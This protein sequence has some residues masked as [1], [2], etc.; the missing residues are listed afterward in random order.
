MS[1][2]YFV[3]NKFLNTKIPVDELASVAMVGFTKALNHYDT[4]RNV[5]LSTYAYNC[6]RNEILFFLRKE[7]KHMVNNVSLNHVL[8]T[9]KDGGSFVVEDTISAEGIDEVDPEEQ[10]I[11]SDSNKALLEVVA[12]L[13]DKERFIIINR[14][15]LFNHKVL[16]QKDIANQIGMSQANVSKIEKLILIKLQKELSKMGHETPF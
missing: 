2:V 1:L 16:T 13:D 15:G 14:F 7:N 12:K 6:M 10:L 11:E 3:A 9:D 8:S 5:K 4:E